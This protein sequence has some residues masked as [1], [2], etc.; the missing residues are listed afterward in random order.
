MKTSFTLCILL[1]LFIGLNGNYAQTT[2]R[3]S[4]SI[5]LKSIG[6]PLYGLDVN[7]YDD[8]NQ[9][10]RQAGQGLPQVQGAQ[11]GTSDQ[12]HLLSTQGWRLVQR[13][14]FQRETVERLQR[15]VILKL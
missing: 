13:S 14:L 8:Q 11:G 6:N 7:L 15:V 12:P 5:P 9:D 3:H 2:K 10:Q 4:G 1:F